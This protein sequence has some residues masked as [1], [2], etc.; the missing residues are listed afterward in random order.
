MAK[1]A[2]GIANWDG[3]A[4]LSELVFLQNSEITHIIR[5]VLFVD[6]GVYRG[7]YIRYDSSNINRN[8]HIISNIPC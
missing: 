7:L 8:K 1:K 6:P 3:L 4:S 2:F 5:F